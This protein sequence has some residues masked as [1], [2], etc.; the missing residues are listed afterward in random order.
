MKDSP[1]VRLAMLGLGALVILL[2]F[3]GGSAWFY[4]HGF[5][6]RQ[7]ATLIGSI[8]SIST[9]LGLYSLYRRGGNS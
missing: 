1:L 7:T 9:F 3:V 5:I 2:L 8:G 6:G 4:L